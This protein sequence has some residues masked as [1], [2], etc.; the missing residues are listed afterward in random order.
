VGAGRM[1]PVFYWVGIATLVV[2]TVYS[3]FSALNFM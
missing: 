3:A 2:W 1:Y